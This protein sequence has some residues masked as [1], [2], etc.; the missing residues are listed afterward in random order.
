MIHGA[1]K[2]GFKS[3]SWDVQNLL[4][5]MFNLF[6]DAPSQRSLYIKESGSDV[7]PKPCVNVTPVFSG[8][9]EIF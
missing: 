5:A 7:F 6:H 1:F 8:P 2:S 4:K 9:E 3:V